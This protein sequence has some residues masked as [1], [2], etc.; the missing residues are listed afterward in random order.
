MRKIFF[1]IFYEKFCIIYKFI[2]FAT[3]KHCKMAIQS[4]QYEGIIIIV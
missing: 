4:P 3:S 1:K 2:T